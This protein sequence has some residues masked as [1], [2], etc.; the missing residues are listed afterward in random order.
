MLDQDQTASP[1]QMS[2]PKPVS[3]SFEARRQALL[4]KLSSPEAEEEDRRRE[5]EAGRARI[6]RERAEAEG[7]ANDLVEKI[8]QRYKSCTLDSFSIYDPRQRV[9]IGEIRAFAADLQG[10]IDAGRN[11]LFFGPPG[12]GKDHLLVALLKEARARLG[13]SPS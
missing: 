1:A 2:T 8:G 13:V 10:E 11:V 9:I 3:E 7:R 5:A 12:T 4:A 6:A